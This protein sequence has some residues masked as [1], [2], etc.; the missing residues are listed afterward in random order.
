M[1]PG[2]SNQRLPPGIYNY[3]ASDEISGCRIGSGGGPIDMALSNDGRYF[4]TLEG[5]NG[6]MTVIRVGPGGPL[7]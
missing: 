1:K 7:L 2:G 3:V 6:T 4:Y 5:G